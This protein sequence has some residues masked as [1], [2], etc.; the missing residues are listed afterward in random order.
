MLLDQ[1]CLIV[2]D[3]RV[4]PTKIPCLAKGISAG[5]WVD[6]ESS[7]AFASGTQPAV[8]CKRAWDAAGGRRRDFKVGCP[9][10]AAAVASCT[11]QQDRW[12]VP[13]LAVRA[14]FDCVRWTCQV[15]QPLRPTLLCLASWLPALDKSR[16]CKSAEVQRV[17]EIYDDCSSSLGMMLTP[18]RV[19]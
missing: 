2:G 10:V 8:T 7:W 18:G 11:V 4:E 9:L 3:F 13:H 5:L 14:L 17:R 6:L 12:V 15:T 16:G 1:P 19:A